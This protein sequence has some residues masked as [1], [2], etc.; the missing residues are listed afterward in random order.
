MIEDIRALETGVLTRGCIILL[1]YVVAVGP[2]SLAATLTTRVTPKGAEISITGDIAPGDAE[3]LE[4][5]MRR[6]DD[7]SQPVRMLHLDSPGGNL[8]GGIA[9]ARF[10]R[11]HVEVSI[12]V[13]DGATCASACFLAF[14][15]GAEK[16]VSANSFV[17]VHGAAD[18]LGHVTADSVAA[19]VAM[20]RITAE[21]GVPPQITQKIVATAPSEIAWLTADD[22]RSMGVT[23]VERSSPDVGTSVVGPAPQPRSDPA[24]E[25]TAAA[26]RSDYET[27]IGLWRQLAQKGLGAA[28]YNLGEMYYA[29]LGVEKDF[30]Q[31]AGWYKRAAERGVPAAQF[32]VGMAYALGRGLPR[33][34]KKAYVWLERAANSYTTAAERAR[35]AKARDLVA[36]HMTPGDVA[37]AERLTYGWAHSQ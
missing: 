28:Q 21:L 5:L 29:G 19:T 3:A 1:I 10:I 30:A 31:A 20:A 33:D 17:G 4:A 35:A 6:I 2:S 27:A 18:R 12:V 11:R 32:S 16:Y 8:V 24:A 36:A 23:I 14:S 26:S 13:D 22:L 25:A 7:S 37:A 34:L 15:A 9:L